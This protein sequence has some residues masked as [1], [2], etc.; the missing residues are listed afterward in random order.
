[1]S[2]GS[3][4]TLKACVA[5]IGQIDRP[6]HRFVSMVGA[7]AQDGSSNRYDV[8]QQ[9]SEKTGGKHF[10]LP[11]PLM[12]DSEAE[13]AQW[14]NHRLYRIVDE[15]ANNADVSFVGIGN[16]RVNCPLHEDGFITRAEV[17]ELMSVGAIAEWLGLPIDRQGARVTSLRLDTPPRRPTPSASQA[18]SANAMRSSPR[19]RVNGSRASSR[20]TQRPG[21]PR[22]LKTK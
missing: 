20:R 8:A 14:V 3:S 2:I 1:M 9:L 19:S 6:Q 4:R 18:A 17:D 12:V 22:R 16:V 7:I 10:M 21:R 15:L 13:R 11:A 5:Q